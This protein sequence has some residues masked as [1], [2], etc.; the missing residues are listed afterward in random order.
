M[1][2]GIEQYWDAPQDHP[3]FGDWLPGIAN[4]D[5]YRDGKASL[6]MGQYIG[7]IYSS[8]KQGKSRDESLKIAKQW[9]EDEWAHN[10]EH[11]VQD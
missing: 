3:E 8:L 1:K 7:N 5:S 6:R 4:F 2:S 9:Y 10:V 11:Y